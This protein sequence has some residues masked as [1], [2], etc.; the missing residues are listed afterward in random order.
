[1]MSTNP[2]TTGILPRK[3]VELIAV[4]LNAGRT[5][6]NPAGM[7][8]HVRAALEA[9]ATRDEVLA[10]LKMASLVSIDSC[11]LGAPILLE[12]A[13]MGEL[14][15]VRAERAMRSPAGA[16]P[17][18]DKLKAAGQWND[19]WDSFASLAPAW[20]EQY[21][22]TRLDIHASGVRSPKLVELL[23]I[24]L[25]ASH[26]HMYAPGTRR[27][28]RAALKLG[29]T[30]VEIMEVLKLCA[31]QGVQACNLGVP[32]LAEELAS[33]ASKAPGDKPRPRS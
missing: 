17:A 32:I 3:S 25:D 16:T 8:S 9:G 28:V 2:W 18:C 19:A 12:E 14:D 1:M 11:S 4:A 6:L 21:M 10:V 27:H 22:A 29:A 20:T 5:N 24:A 33:R 31:T 30:V 23:G 13:S 15:A 7:R 26:A